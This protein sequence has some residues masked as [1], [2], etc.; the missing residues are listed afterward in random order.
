[1]RTNAILFCASALFS[2]MISSCN[3]KA[4]IEKWPEMGNHYDPN[5]PIAFESMS[6]DW[7]RINQNFVITGNFPLDLSK[8][9]VYFGD[10]EAVLVNCDGRDLYGLVPKQPAGKKEVTMVVDGTTYTLDDFTFKYYLTESVITVVGKFGETDPHVVGNLDE[11]RLNSTSHLAA[12]SGQDGDNLIV[13]CGGWNDKIYLVSF[14]DNMMIQLTGIGFMGSVATNNSR[15]GVA[16]VARDNGQIFTANRSDGWTLNATG[17]T[18]PFNGGNNQG[19]M[20]FAEDDRYVYIMASDA[21]YRIDLENKSSEEMFKVS[22][23]SAEFSGINTSQWRYYLTYSKYDKAFFCS[24]PENNGIFKYWQEEDGTW[25]VERYAGFKASWEG[26][27][28]TGDRLNDAVLK[29]PNGMCVNSLGELYVALQGAHCIVKIVGREVSLV[30]GHPN[31][32]GRVNG[33]PTE[34]YFDSPLSIVLDG[35]ENFFIGEDNTGV[36]RKMTIE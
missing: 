5:K 19:N 28:V 8:I 1:M 16:I 36:I 24:Y 15:N 30:A 14:D 26:D 17:I 3:G 21:L 22:Q 23:F 11:A 12:V 29:N 4:E 10:R 25:K 33:T 2:L 13:S 27:N 35:E 31:H 34:A 18:Y 20:C 32:S 7:G 6:P 9:K